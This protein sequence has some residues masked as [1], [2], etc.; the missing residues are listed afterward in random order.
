MYVLW[1]THFFEWSDIQFICIS[2]WGHDLWV[3]VQHKFKRPAFGN[4]SH[5][6][7]H[8]FLH[9]KMIPLILRSADW[10]IH[11]Y[12]GLWAVVLRAES[13]QC[14]GQRWN[15]VGSVREGDLC[16]SLKCS[17]NCELGTTHLTFS[18]SSLWWLALCQHHLQCVSGSVQHRTYNLWEN[19]RIS[20]HQYCN[21]LLERRAKT[22]N[23]H[24]WN[25]CS[26][27]L[28]KNPWQEYELAMEMYL[29]LSQWMGH[30]SNACLTK[31]WIGFITFPVNGLHICVF[32]CALWMTL[33]S[34]LGCHV[35]ARAPHW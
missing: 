11:I 31:L 26:P 1:C 32:M 21:I 12:A 19:Y 14:I 30:Y 20:E 34:P 6:Q 33:L 7:V 5:Q 23:G 18:A 27:N 13:L 3:C 9:L 16:K 17:F 35:S 28:E 10:A 15:N 22:D 25:T 4:R 29:W 8:F 24:F 2:A